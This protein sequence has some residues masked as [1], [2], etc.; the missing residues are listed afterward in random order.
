M[1]VSVV[2]VNFNAGSRLRGCLDHLAAQTLQPDEI[3]V[4]D[5]GSS[6]NSFDAA[7]DRQDVLASVIKPRPAGRNLGFAA[8]NNLA[9]A[10]AAGEWLA[11]L[12]PDAYPE[13]DWLERL[14][15]AARR[16]PD[17]EAFGSLQIDA[18][19]P[20]ILDGCGDVCS[21]FGL[22]YR[23]GHGEPRASAPTTDYETFAPC[24]AAA[25]YKRGRFMALGG[26]DERFF[27]YGEDVDL[28]FRLRNA[29]GRCVQVS[30][31]IVRHE[32]SGITGKRSDFSVYHGH[33]NRIWVFYKNMPFLLY[34]MT[35]PLRL[36]G[37][38]L[39]FFKSLA[40]GVSVSYLRG[41]RDG[42]LGL[43]VLEADR[44]RIASDRRHARSKVARALS[45]SPLKLL[46]RAPDPRVL[47]DR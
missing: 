7:T 37:D 16:H 22:A 18:A 27:C 42:Y 11:F 12:N 45:W 17:V 3:I 46:T 47:S 13:P 28:G 5:N 23:G 29:G 39:L 34:W 41:V 30:D 15:E 8:A 26:F 24:A 14:V 33:R 43:G 20:T 36:V 21:V 4:V 35:T 31:A 10:D 25:L 32:G 1:R 40:D 38:I 2:I 19:N 9:A 6:D 44:R